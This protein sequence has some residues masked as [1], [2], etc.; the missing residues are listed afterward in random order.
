MPVSS[1]PAY[2]LPQ[3]G[4]WPE[5]RVAWTPRRSET[6]LLVHDLQQYFLRPYDLAA[7]PLRTVLENI[8]RLIQ[9]CRVHNV[10]VIFSAQPGE[11]SQAERGLLWDVWGQG[12][13]AAPELS[14]FLPILAPEAGDIVVEKRRYS[15]FYQTRLA[16]VLDQ[17]ACTDLLITGVYGHI[18][19]LAT[20]TDGFM[21]GVRPFLL[22]DAIADFSLTDHLVALRQ[23]ARTCGVVTTT[24]DV[25]GLLAGLVDESHAPGLALVGKVRGGRSA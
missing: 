20:A 17:H 6:A 23:V 8:C 9:A 13:I 19:C 11:Q 10:P 16:E 24:S 4:D 18:G 7:E 2:P 3:S 5:A 12:I 22:A 14:G 25:L 15:A 1:I 21:Q